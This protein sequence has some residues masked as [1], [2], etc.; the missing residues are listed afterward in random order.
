LIEGKTPGTVGTGVCRG[1]DDL[2]R[3]TKTSAGQFRY[4][5]SLADQREN[6]L[7]SLVG[8]RDH[9]GGSLAQDLRLGE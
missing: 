8:L 5:L 9:R 2:P 3:R 7:L 6:A 4:S 1:S